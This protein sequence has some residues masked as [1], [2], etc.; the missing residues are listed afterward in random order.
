[1]YQ[2]VDPKTNPIGIPSKTKYRK[3]TQR[4]EKIRDAG[5]GTEKEKQLI[6]NLLSFGYAFHQ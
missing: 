6:I 4:E 5:G 3:L 1:M 2:Y